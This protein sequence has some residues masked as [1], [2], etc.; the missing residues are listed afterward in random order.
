[1]NKKFKWML[2]ALVVALLAVGAYGVT[3]AYADDGDTG[4]PFGGHG[5]RGGRGL[6]GAGLEAI[7]EVLGMEPEEMKTALQEGKTLQELADEAG[8]DM[9]EIHEVMSALREDAAA[10]R[11]QAMRDHIAQALAD[12][13]MSQEQADWMLEGLDKGYFFNSIGGFGGRGGKFHSGEEFNP[14]Q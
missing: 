8:V 14:P 4:R 9:E 7:A 12:G 2:G 10:E 11:E 5:G 1:M 6:D 3:T 13:T